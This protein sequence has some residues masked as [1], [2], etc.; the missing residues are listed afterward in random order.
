MVSFV[1]LLSIIVSFVLARPPQHILFVV[2]DDLG[3]S[4]LAYKA[5]M[6]NLDGPAFSSPFLDSLAIGG[7]RLESTYVHALCSPSRTAFLS[8]RYAY[9]TG[10]N[11]EVIVNGVPDQLPTNIRTA[12]DLLQTHGWKTWA[13]SHSFLLHIDLF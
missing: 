3:F 6:Y 2:V 13:G 7:V 1:L 9:T 12:A 10:M 5:Q 8:G 4:D 11:A